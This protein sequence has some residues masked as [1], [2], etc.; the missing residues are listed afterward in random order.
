MLQYSS[1][2]AVAETIR[3]SP[4]TE[5]VR[6]RNTGLKQR[7]SHHPMN[8]KEILVPAVLADLRTIDRGEIR[9]VTLVLPESHQIAGQVYPIRDR[10]RPGNAFLA[11][12]FGG[13]TEKLRRRMYTRSNCSLKAQRVLETIINHTHQAKADTSV[14]WQGEHVE[15]LQREGGTIEVRVALNPDGTELV[16]YENS[17]ACKA[18]NLRLEPDGEWETLR[19]L[20][21]AFSTGITPFLAH[22]RYMKALGFGRRGSHPGC[23]YQLIVSVRSPR[24]LLEH[25]ELLDLERA[26]PENFKYHPVLTR[27]WPDDWPF[28]KGRIIRITEGNDREGRV[29]LGP[30]REVVPDLEK[31]HVRMCGNATA[32]DQL[33]RGLQQDDHR[34]LS[35]RSEVW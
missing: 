33:L 12:P 20:G 18:A 9:A 23:R 16:L 28:G 22:V 35:F 15:A 19:F 1:A 26:F 21:L 8:G 3:K 7:R 32:R 13:R 11:K 4:L 10:M 24:H 6:E 14:W 27:E 5:V 34:V 17:T 29:D 30:L 31:H 25:E 2:P